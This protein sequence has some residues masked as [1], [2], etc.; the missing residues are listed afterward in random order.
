MLLIHRQTH[1]AHL[2]KSSHFL[3]SLR[4]HDAAGQVLH[5]LTWSLHTER[6]DLTHTHTHTLSAT[7]EK[8]TFKRL[9]GKNLIQ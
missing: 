9:G 6:L 4:H 7:V 2:S 5:C 8:F 3:Q 1:G